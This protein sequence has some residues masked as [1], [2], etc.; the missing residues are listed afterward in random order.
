MNIDGDDEPS[1]VI[2]EILDDFCE[3]EIKQEL[4]GAD[5]TDMADDN[6]ITIYPSEISYGQ[7][8]RS[9]DDE[10]DEEEEETNL[11]KKTQRLNIYYIDSF[12]LRA[13]QVSE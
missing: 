13:C 12:Y 5:I 11:G 8:E 1:L 9:K 2:D 4:D 6:L 3:F 7:E 10:G